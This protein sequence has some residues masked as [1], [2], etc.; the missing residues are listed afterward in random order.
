MLNKELSQE[1][2]KRKGL[3]LSIG[4]MKT[5]I[6]Y[7]C[8]EASAKAFFRTISVNEHQALAYSKIDEKGEI[9]NHPDALNE[10]Y[11]A[12]KALMKI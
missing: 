3:F 7:T 5:E 1:P 10:A 2:V 4:G 6:G 12:G 9:L 8:S 11:E